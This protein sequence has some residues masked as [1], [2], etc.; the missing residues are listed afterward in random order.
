MSDT[1]GLTKLGSQK[2][3]YLYDKP[4]KDI[5]ETF[6]NVH[7]PR[8]YVVPF[9]CN[10]FTSLCPKTGQPDFATMHIFYVPDVNMVES[11]SLK[12]YLFSYRQHGEFHEDCTNSILNDLKAKLN[13]HYILICAD[14]NVRGGIAIKP[15]VE[16]KRRKL[17]KSQVA[18]IRWQIEQ[19]W[20]M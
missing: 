2:T 4:N 12:L 17:T 15:V 7:H 8:L 19:Y 6:K 10:E 18:D 3:K 20:K 13:P 1:K 9:T 5:M 11:K 16:W 14:F